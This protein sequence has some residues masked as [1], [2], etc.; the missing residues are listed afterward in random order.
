EMQRF[1]FKNRIVNARDRRQLKF[2]KE[3]HLSDDFKALWD[4]IKHR[5]RYRVAFDT[6]DLIAKATKRIKDLEPIRPVRIAM[7]RVDVDISDAGVSTDRKL[8]EKSREASGVRV[9]PDLL[10]YL[11]KE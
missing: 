9:L 1:V 8:E 3:V 4:Q 10:A 5:T 7:T 11:Q 6:A 2:R